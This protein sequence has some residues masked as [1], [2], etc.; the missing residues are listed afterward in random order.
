MIIPTTLPA[1]DHPPL[2]WLAAGLAALSLALGLWAQLRPG[3]GVRVVGQRPLLQGLGLALVL[4]GAG[5]GLAGPRGGAVEA[6]RLTV[7]VLLDASRS[8]AVPD[9][10]G[11][12][13]W[14]A[15]VA[16][17]DRLWSRPNPGVRFGLGL[18]TG[19]AVL[20]VPPGEDQRLLRDALRVAGPGTV[21]SAGTSLGLGLPQ[22]AAW[23]SP[24][25]P[26][27]LLLL[28]DGEETVESPAEALER[29]AAALGRVR[30]PVL[31]V[32]L[33][34][35]VA[36]AVPAAPGPEAET[37]AGGPPP[38]KVGR[39]QP[40]PAGGTPPAL[41]SLARPD[42]LRDLAGRTGGWVA[43]PGEDLGERFQR[44]ALGR[45][46]LPAVRSRV[47]AHPEWGAWPALA[48]LALWLLAA[49]RPM[50]AWRPILVLAVALGLGGAAAGQGMPAAGP[51]APA[52]RPGALPA[53]APQPVLVPA[54]IRAWLA[55]R[56]LDR[57][58]LA[59][60]RRW[61]PPSGPARYRLLAARI[62]LAA[63]AWTE[64]LA[65][66]APLTGQGAP[67][68]LPPW[69]APALLLA[70]R[71][72]AGLGRA[73]EARALLE[74]LLLEEPGRPEAVHNLQALLRDPGPPPPP[75][76]KPPP[77]PPQPNQGA[78]QDELD[79]L[80]QRLPRNDHPA[81]VKDL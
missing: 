80:R 32:P 75:A 46:P 43:T 6:P 34:Q 59:G 53:D 5:L 2:L 72:Q 41:T 28:S 36:Q 45:D 12:S 58:D 4:G 51:A 20:V 76:R 55:Q 26:A 39:T 81:G 11:A 10:G 14:Q 57:G 77:P 50:R 13:R 64:A 40:A 24:G 47:P 63:E 27:V 61:K 25:E 15:A 19:D 70:A 16:L 30:L 65:D 8:M 79:G 9:C 68:P 73:Q 74:R 49:G 7:L 17:L 29:A 3:L 42:L 22:A 62:D 37:P 1:F 66:L 31:A 38:A 21:G 67:R 69:R 18:L 48:G 52:A 44:L 78:R 54:G 56:A 60:A 33:G 35:P 23:V 71:A